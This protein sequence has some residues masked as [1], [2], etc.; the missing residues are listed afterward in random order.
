MEKNAQYYL[1]YAQKARANG[2][3]GLAD[4]ME[5]FAATLQSRE[6]EAAPVETSEVASATSAVPAPEGQDSENKDKGF[7]GAAAEVPVGIA[8][9]V[10]SA[11]VETVD[12]A[13]WIKDSTV[14]GF[15]TLDPNLADEETLRVWEEGGNVVFYNGAGKEIKWAR[16]QELQDLRALNV[17]NYLDFSQILDDNLIYTADDARRGGMQE[18]LAGSMSSGASQFIGGW[19]GLGKVKTVSKLGNKLI[20]GKGTGAKAVKAGVKGGIVD[21]TVFPEHEARA[22]DF[23]VEMGVEAEFI[24]WLASDKEDTVLEGK[25][26][27]AIEGVVAGGLVD[28]IMLGFRA[29]RARKIAERAGDNV[30]KADEMNKEATELV[31]E[32]ET[33]F[34]P[35]NEADARD[36]DG[37]PIKTIDDADADLNPPKVEEVDEVKSKFTAK[38]DEIM[39]KNGWVITHSVEETSKAI[40]TNVGK[41]AGDEFDARVKKIAQDKLAERTGSKKVGLDE[42]QAPIGAKLPDPE[43]PLR[44]AKDNQKHRNAKGDHRDLEGG[45]TKHV[46]WKES[47]AAAKRL[48][49][50]LLKGEDGEGGVGLI[51]LAKRFHQF[52]IDPKDADVFAAAALQLETTIWKQFEALARTPK[53]INKDPDT[54]RKLE[55]LAEALRYAQADRMGGASSN[56][57][58]LALQKQA[59]EVIPTLDFELTPEGMVRTLNMEANAGKVRKTWNKMNNIVNMVNEYWLNSL[60]SGWT[61]HAINLTSNAVVSAVDILEVAGGAAIA[62]LKNPSEGARQLLLA[63]RQAVGII[64]Y[65]RI[66]A[67]VA[68]QTLRHGRNILDEEGMVNEAVNNIVGDVAIGS[69]NVDITKIFSDPNLSTMDRIGNI[70]RLPSRGL[71]GGDELFKQLNFRAKAYAYAAEEVDKMIGA[72]KIKAKDF[73][74]NVEKRLDDAYEAARSAKKGDV[75]TDIVAQKGLKAARMNTF[76]ND[77]GSQ[78]KAL[79]GFVGD[80]PLL[81]QVIP[82]IRTPIN[83]LKYPLRR[84]P[85]KLTQKSFYESIEKGGEEASQAIF[86]VVMG[87]ATWAGVMN[88]VY[89][90]VEIPAGN[91]DVMPVDKYQGSWATY[92]NYQKAA[93]RA[94][95]ASPNSRYVDGEWVSYQRLD[96]AAMFVGVAADLRDVLESGD[97]E[98]G[99]ETSTAAIIAI[100]AQFKDKTYT[101]GLS[102]FI[103][104]LDEPERHAE[105]YLF[106][107]AGSFVP[108]AV[109]QFNH[110]QNTREV[111][112][113]ADAAMNRI[114]GLS[115]NLEATYDILGEKN[116]KAGGYIQKRT[117]WKD[118]VV[119]SEM[120]RLA[121][122]IG[123]ISER[124]SSG[125][126]LP[127]F[128]LDDGKSAYLRLNE[129]VGETK[130]GGRTLKEAL[131]KKILSRHYQGTLT[132]GERT[133]DGR[134]GSTREDAL[135]KIFRKYRN[136]AMD[137]LRRESPEL[138]QMIKQKERQQKD[139]GYQRTA[140]ND[141]FRRGQNQVDTPVERR[142]DLLNELFD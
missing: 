50:K 23:A 59:K 54:V 25:I 70:I 75:I 28:T 77:L 57:R 81:R 87:T 122:S 71:M 51:E 39:A 24:R 43:D 99:M 86:Q 10:G 45:H 121:P 94:S 48:I 127:E 33:K 111:R 119:R 38:A 134:I 89:E 128:I 112:S 131:E 11:V 6:P 9:G 76:T 137:T 136:K 58:A 1:D 12:T 140:G 135:K 110:D 46:S 138:D 83:I 63:K 73:D 97:T 56:A 13:E 79:Q 31:E 125:V 109:S 67:K 92:T 36:F 93:L 61:T 32:L 142:K 133:S 42:S 37:R 108:S 34:K 68:G 115:Q 62:T 129:L 88:L 104:A 14:G 66:S 114:P 78:G 65:A 49:T 116:V 4:R 20:K 100:A 29:I 26:K 69:G 22:S 41:K 105:Q 141:V 72:G 40:H 18:T 123:K 74:A 130:M 126:D 91:G 101:K 53:A 2:D 7:L 132:N 102:D 107:K 17:A 27:N 64:K 90:Q 139:A 3:D 117:V 16:G 96:P 55:T 47:N 30:A 95:G 84:S 106:Q 82:F 80:V 52:K 44:G 21:F 118:D 60:L 120:Y 15:V 124:H 85:L 98:G 35:T 103:K 8:A 19:I 5:A 113:L